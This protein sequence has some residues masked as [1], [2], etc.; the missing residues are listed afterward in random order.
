MS[1]L[2]GWTLKCI[3][4]VTLAGLAIGLGLMIFAGSWMRVDDQPEQ[5]DYIIPLAG[6]SD[7]L[8]TA[9]RLYK[10][11]FAP[12]I[13]L[14]NA[15]SMPP[16]R[17]EKLEWQMGYPNYTDTEYCFRL[18]GLLGVDPGETESFGN[19]HISTVEEAEALRTFLDGRTPSLLLVT[20][21]SH[22]RRAKMIFEDVL[23]D[24]RILVKTSENGS[25]G[26]Q[27]WKDQTA[28]QNLILEF[29]KTIHYLLGGGFRST[30]DQPAS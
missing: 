18:L 25:F 10:Q 30:D 5:V 19:G 26:K 3:G 21:P 11:G 15:K 8:I 4:A 23:P 6:D 7:R 20:S 2:F 16:S 24:C 27:W 22:A 1:R 28:A 12:V 14:S 29:A 13:L 9:A 17:L